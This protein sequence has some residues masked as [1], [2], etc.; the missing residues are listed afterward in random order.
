MMPQG[1]DF[2]GF[3]RIFHN[4]CRRYLSLYQDESMAPRSSK[5][6][7]IVSLSMN[8]QPLYHGW[9]VDLMAARNKE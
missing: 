7:L 1:S 3:K 5:L 9:S 6:N 8:L 4:M 2:V